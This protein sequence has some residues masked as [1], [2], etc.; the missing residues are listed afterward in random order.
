M[1]WPLT[2]RPPTGASGPPI[3]FS[4]VDRRRGPAQHELAGI[5]AEVNVRQNV[6][7]ATV[8]F[9]YVLEFDHG[10]YENGKMREGAKG[11]SPSTARTVMRT[12][13]SHAC[14]CTLSLPLNYVRLWSA[15]PSRRLK[16]AVR[17]MM[18]GYVQRFN[19]VR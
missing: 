4:S 12:K 1:R 5:N 9:E 15:M 7:A 16:S 14:H 13:L 10:Q 18:Q 11:P 17:G 19:W 2:E 6:S 8:R 3:S